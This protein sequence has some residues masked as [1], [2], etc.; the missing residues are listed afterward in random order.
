MTTSLRCSGGAFGFNVFSFATFNLFVNGSQVDRGQIKGS[1]FGF[2]PDD[3]SATTVVTIGLTGYYSS[4][5]NIFAQIGGVDIEAPTIVA[6]IHPV[7]PPPLLPS[8][9]SGV[10]EPASWVM[11]I[12]GFG[13]V[14]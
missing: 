9:P 14:G 13:V 5:P 2:I 7:Q 8:D 6:P 4:S 1:Y 3:D 12:G 10:P 11:M